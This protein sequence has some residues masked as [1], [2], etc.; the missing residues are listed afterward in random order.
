VF[1]GFTTFAMPYLFTTLFRNSKVPGAQVVP[2][3]S[4]FYA[5]RISAALWEH[6]RQGGAF[7][8]QHYS[9][10][11]AKLHFTKSFNAVA[12]A[13]GKLNCELILYIPAK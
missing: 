9:Y 4:V 7:G 6:L 5:K 3:G 11:E 8:A 13:G 10:A 2:H 1:I 12:E